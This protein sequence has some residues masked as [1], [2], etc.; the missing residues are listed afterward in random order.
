MAISN[1]NL[2]LER[3]GVNM[4]IRKV[5]QWVEY[6]DFTDGGG[7]DGTLNLTNKIPAGSFVLGSKVKVTEGFTGD[8]TC[9]LDIGNSG[10]PDAYSYTTHNIFA[11]A[12]NLVEGADGATGGNQGTGLVP[13]SSE[14]T[15][16]LTA[17]GGSDWTDVTAGKMFVE[18][19][20]LSTNLEVVTHYP[21]RY[22]MFNE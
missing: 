10:D 4:S 13:V 15:V 5:A 8:T 20:Y 19:F 1:V 16:L 18:I 17:T 22:N 14:T 7:T 6:S 21:N 2:E 3:S 11:A 9:V 12:D